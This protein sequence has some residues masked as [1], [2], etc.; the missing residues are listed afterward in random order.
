MTA[1]SHPRTGHAP[2]SSRT[3]DG[4]RRSVYLLPGHLVAAAEP[5]DVTTILGSCVAVCL[6]DRRGRAGGVNH[7]L[8]PHHPPTQPRSPRFGSV[9]IRE[10]IDAVCAHGTR[11]AD[12]RAHVFG[13]AGVIA[14]LATAWRQVGQQ[15]VELAEQMLADEG[16]TVVERDLGGTRGRRLRFRTDDGAAHVTLI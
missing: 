16:I 12:L 13:G 6:F 4:A 14:G 5:C 15:N 11:R 3:A 9:A 10:L 7:F 2:P 8:L 1:A